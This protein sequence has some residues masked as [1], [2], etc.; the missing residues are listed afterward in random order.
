M[1]GHVRAAVHSKEVPRRAPATEYVAT[2]DGSSSAA[3]VMRPG[4]R[5]EKKRRTGLRVGSPTG[6]PSVA[7]RVG[8]VIC[9]SDDSDRQEAYAVRTKIRSTSV[10]NF[11][12][13]KL[14]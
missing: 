8:V 14:L 6:S 2:P 9:H 7:V 1:S 13:A 3:P 10:T 4:P 11:C 12:G 5:A